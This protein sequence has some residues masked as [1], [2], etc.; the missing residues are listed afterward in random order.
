MSCTSC[1]RKWVEMFQPVTG[2]P[3]K[4]T[5]FPRHTKGSLTSPIGAATEP[6]TKSQSL[7]YDFQFLCVNKPQDLDLASGTLLAD[8]G[9]FRAVQ[10]TFI[11]FLAQIYKV[12]K[13]DTKGCGERASESFTLRH[14][15]QTDLC[16]PCYLGR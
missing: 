14:W 3:P 12:P 2:F 1:P 7:T 4:L 9:S 10:G 6:G 8:A 5:S 13:N 16:S 15:R 11:H